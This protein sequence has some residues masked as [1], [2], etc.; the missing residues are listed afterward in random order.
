MISSILILSALDYKKSVMEKVANK[1]VK[2]N[3]NNKKVT[4]NIIVVAII[5]FST[6]IVLNDASIMCKMNNFY[7]VD[8]IKGE[9]SES[10][11]SYNDQIDY[12]DSVHNEDYIILPLKIHYSVLM[13]TPAY[14]FVEYCNFS[15][16]KWVPLGWASQ[17]EYFYKVL[18]SVGYSSGSDLLKSVAK[19]D[20]NIVLCSVESFNDYSSVQD[21]LDFFFT[22]L[23]EHYSE[24]IEKSQVEYK[25][26]YSREIG[27][28]K[29]IHY[30][31]L[32]PSA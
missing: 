21:D 24:S 6:L 14:P 2:F 9:V 12:L 26:I 22:Y 3:K 27:E 18:D 32:I 16:S 29:V 7:L 20:E 28:N 8:Y 19:G 13:T 1:F 15:K 5:I 17:S 4:M 31:K 30:F 25:K 10:N 23:D 11:K